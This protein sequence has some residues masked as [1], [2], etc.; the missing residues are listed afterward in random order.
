MEQDNT[1]LQGVLTQSTQQQQGQGLDSYNTY[2]TIFSINLT[3]R[4]PS[5]T[6]LNNIETQNVRDVARFSV[7]CS[8]IARDTWEEVNSPKQ[9]K[10]LS[11]QS[12]VA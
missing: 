4:F 1:T 3:H 10:G 5:V 11:R 8:M 12:R 9:Q 7:A 6:D 2:L